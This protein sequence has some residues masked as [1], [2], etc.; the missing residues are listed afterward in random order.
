[1]NKR[2]KWKAWRDF[3]QR[4]KTQLCVSSGGEIFELTDETRLKME[5]YVEKN[6]NYTRDDFGANATH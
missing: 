2:L 3:L 5:D 6:P 1:M 4:S